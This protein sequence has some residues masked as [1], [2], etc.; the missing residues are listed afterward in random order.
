MPELGQLSEIHRYPVKSMQ[1]EQLSTVAIGAQGLRGDRVWAIRDEGRGGIEG[2]RKLPT[3]LSCHARFT[4]PVPEAGT[5]PVPEVEFSDGTRFYADNPEVARRAGEEAE[6]ELSLWPQVPA[7]KIE[8][9]KRGAPDNAD[10]MAEL[11]SIFGRLEDEPL[12]DLGTFPIESLTSATIPGTYFDCYPI[13]LLSE[14]SLQS[15]R[16]AQ[17]ESIFDVRRFRPNLLIES[18]EHEG[19]PENAWVGKRIRIGSCVFKIAMECPRCVMTTHPMGDLPKDPSIMR[20][21]VKQNAGNL[22]VYASVES[23]G[24]VSRGDA[25]ELLAD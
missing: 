16:E 2:A 24:T 9:Y 8:H 1:G 15:M 11:R 18:L 7:D 13:L 3:L 10:F 14:T 25:I 21:L 23:F 6:R 12:P 22:G 17:P 4:E 5:C 20:T 19:F